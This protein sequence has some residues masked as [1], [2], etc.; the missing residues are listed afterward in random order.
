MAS[1]LSR[2]GDLITAIG[3]DMKLKA[4]VASPTFTGTLTAPKLVLPPVVLTD[5]ATIATNAASG[6]WFRCTLTASRTLGAPTNPTDGQRVTWEL[7][8]SGGA[9]TPTLTV[10]SSGAF[11]FGSDLTALSAI[12]SGTTDIIGA[13]YN[14]AAARW[15]VVSYIKGF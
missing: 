7:T 13:V 4:P 1:L 15:W 6:N 5:A 2:L 8:A 9:W 11:A 3:A 10:G 12:A 14:T